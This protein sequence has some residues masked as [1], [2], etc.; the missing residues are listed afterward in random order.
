MAIFIG[1]DAFDWHCQFFE[2]VLNFLEQ[3]GDI[4][5]GTTEQGASQQ[6]LLWF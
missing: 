6:D 2:Q 4:T 5:L 3:A 1:D